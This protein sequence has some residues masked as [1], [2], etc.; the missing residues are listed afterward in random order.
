ME[1]TKQLLIKTGLNKNTKQLNIP[2]YL[3]KSQP[4]FTPNQ[5][6]PNNNQEIRTS[7][8]KIHI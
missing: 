4:K 2:D 6:K 1:Q 8:N 5:I 7:N 3:P